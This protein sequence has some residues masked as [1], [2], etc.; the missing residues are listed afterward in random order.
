[1]VAQNKQSTATLKENEKKWGKDLMEAGWTAVPSIVLEKQA[2]LGLDSV[3]VNILLHLMT[4]WW[5]ADNKPYPSKRAIAEAM[6]YTPRHIQRKLDA[7]EKAGFIEREQ[8]FDSAG[9][10]L[11]NRYSFNGLIKAVRPYAEEKNQ[12][13]E[14]NRTEEVERRRR[15]GRPK[16]AAVNG[17]IAD[18]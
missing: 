11:S 15:K 2:A 3:E 16:L 17:K 9:G 12:Q 18:D 13:R 1:M 6:N 5:H 14:K 8:R 10:Q 7:L 4:Y